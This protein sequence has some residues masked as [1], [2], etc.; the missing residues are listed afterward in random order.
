MADMDPVVVLP[1]PGL[2]GRNETASWVALATATV[3]RLG[4]AVLAF[5]S[6]EGSARQRA[7]SCAC[8]SAFS[9]SSSQWLGL[10]LS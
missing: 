8:P 7:G 9:E 10:G 4:V 3:C 6:G 5:P 2:D 1:L